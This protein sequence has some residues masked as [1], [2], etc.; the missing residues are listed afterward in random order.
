M[1]GH[2]PGEALVVADD[3]EG[4]ARKAGTD[5]AEAGR[6]NLVLVEDGR[7]GELQMR[8]VGQDGQA[9]AGT[10]SGDHELV[11]AAVIVGILQRR[12]QERDRTQLREIVAGQPHQYRV[13]QG[14][15]GS[16]QTLDAVACRGEVLD[17]VGERATGARPRASRIR[18]G[19]GVVEGCETIDVFEE[20]R[21]A[22]EA[23]RSTFGLVLRQER[24]AIQ[25]GELE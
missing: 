25:I 15:R 6:A 5:G 17:Q 7:G 24:G 21:R 3:D 22:V 12:L 2:T 10:V 1:R 9:G 23:L 18:H 20:Q 11:A 8:I 16:C 14:G 19:G 13:V 4:G